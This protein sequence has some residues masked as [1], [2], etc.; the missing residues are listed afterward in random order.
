M[1]EEEEGHKNVRQRWGG[2]GGGGEGSAK[3][4]LDATNY[5]SRSRVK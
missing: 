4:Y 2:G 5:S 3:Y 1:G